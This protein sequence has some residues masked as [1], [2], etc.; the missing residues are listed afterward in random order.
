MKGDPSDTQESGGDLS[1]AQLL[2]AL[3]HS[4]TRAREAE[5]L[6]Q[7]ACDDKDHVVNL[8]FQQLPYL[9]AYR[10]W[11]RLLQLETL[12]LQLS[13]K[14]DLFA[15]PFPL[16]WVRNRGVAI[17]KNRCNGA[18]KKRPSKKRCNGRKVVF[19]F[20][21]GFS[22]AGAGLLVGWTIAWLFPAF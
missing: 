14:D 5:K 15:P 6:A 11:L 7:K 19:A 8:F 21:I 18:A 9:F 1:R 3:C 17:R 10:Q 4:Q 20:A 12:C 16:P 2:E 22:L 13:S